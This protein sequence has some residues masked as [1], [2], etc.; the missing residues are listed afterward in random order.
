MRIR[1]W[2]QIVFLLF[3]VFLFARTTFPLSSRIPPVDLLFRLDPLGAVVSFVASRT[4]VSRLLLAGITIVLTIL[5]GRFFCGWVCPL[6]TSIDLWRRWIVRTRRNKLPQLDL[7]RAK[8]YIL[9]VVGVAS[10][11]GFS[12]VWFFNPLALFTRFLTFTLYPLFLFVGNVLLDGLRVLGERLDWVFLSYLSLPQAVY[13]AAIVTLLFF[14]GVLFLDVIQ[15]RF[16]CRNLCPLGALL[17]ILSRFR[18]FPRRVEGC[19]DCGECQDACPTSAIPAEPRETVNSECIQCH[20]CAQVCPVDAIS[21]TLGRPLMGP[22]LDLGR[23]R[24]LFLAGAGAVTVV[25]GRLDIIRSRKISNKVRPPGSIPENQFLARCLR[26]GE[27][28]KICPTNGLQPATLEVGWVGLLSPVLVP[29]LGGCERYCNECGAVCPSQAI[30]QLSL[31]EKS[32]VRMGTAA[33]AKERC[34]A[35]EQQKLC[36]ICDEACPFGAIYFREV[37]DALGTSKRP[38][39]NEDVCTG[40]GICEQRCPVA[41]EAAIRVSSMGEERLLTGSYITSGKVLAR[42]LAMEEKEPQEPALPP[43]FIQ[44]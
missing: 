15:S 4:I 42:K 7:R 19:T 9:F 26:C 34:I 18:L 36:L 37:S 10:L 13:G 25:L 44:E 28:M 14:F 23:R 41:G 20:T 3:F 29:R 11:L 12:L 40:C 16:W 35:W 43:G 27:C 39:V 5:I 30:R 33:I 31:Q 2:I 22:S 38:F 6:G 24:L 21:F 32:Y 1:K 8:Y 17:G